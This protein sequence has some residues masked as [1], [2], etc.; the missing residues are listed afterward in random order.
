MSGRARSRSRSPPRHARAA[1]PARAPSGGELIRLIKESRSVADLQAL[2]RTHHAAFN[3][4]HDSTIAHTCAR[5]SQA[6]DAAA[7]D[8]AAQAAR[9]WLGRDV[10]AMGRDGRNAANI[11]WAL[12]KVRADGGA[13]IADMGR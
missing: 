2:A 3:G 11:I 10:R 7:R 4:T 1:P 8:L 12:A 6:G 9:I 5:L 13:L